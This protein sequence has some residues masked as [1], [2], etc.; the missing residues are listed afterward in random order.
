MSDR[1]D[2]STVQ[3]LDRALKLYRRLI[4]RLL[5]IVVLGFV[6]VIAL[7]KLGTALAPPY[8]LYLFGTSLTSWGLIGVLLLLFAELFW[9]GRQIGRALNDPIMLSSPVAALMSG[10]SVIAQRAHAMDMEWSGFLGPL[11]PSRAK[12]SRS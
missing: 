3:E 4:F 1:L 8:G 10:L 12:R 2:Q 9:E 7:S 11:R 6:A 5:A